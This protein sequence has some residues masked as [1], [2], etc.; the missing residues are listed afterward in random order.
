MTIVTY[1]LKLIGQSIKDVVFFPIW[2]YSFGLA[3]ILK[4]NKKFLA[5]REKGLALFVWIVNIFT[6]M[7][8]QYDIQGRIISFFMRLV[9][10][11]FRGLIMIFWLIITFLCVIIWLGLPFLIIYQIF[12]QIT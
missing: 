7:Y 1:N 6:P 12:Y 11:I 9:Q 4:K 10:I 3:Q 2:W 8:G 5:N